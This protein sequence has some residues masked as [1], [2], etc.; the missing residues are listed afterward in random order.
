MYVTTPWHLTRASSRMTETMAIRNNGQSGLSI[1][2][3]CNKSEMYARHN[4]MAVAH[5]RLSF[6]CRRWL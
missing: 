3:V 2:F 4:S 5:L 6:L 1:I